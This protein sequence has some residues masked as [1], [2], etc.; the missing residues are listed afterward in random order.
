MGWL[1][2]VLSISGCAETQ[3]RPAEAAPAIAPGRLTR[4]EIET[5]LGHGVRGKTTLRHLYDER[6]RLVATTRAHGAGVAVTTT[7]GYDAAG[8]LASERID[9]GGGLGSETTYDYDAHGWKTRACTVHNVGMLTVVIPDTCTHYEYDAKGRVTRERT[10]MMGRSG[11]IAASSGVE[12]G[13]VEDSAGR[14]VE[15]TRSSGGQAQSRHTYRYDATGHLLEEVFD[16]LQTPGIEEQ[17]FHTYD[18]G[19]Q[20]ERVRRVFGGNRGTGEAE[21]VYR[22]GRVV[23]A[24]GALPAEESFSHSASSTARYFYGAS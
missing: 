13:Y 18:A 15:E 11:T 22:Q 3:A 5:D 8:R 23:S 24:S 10:E 21:Y 14:V 20:L 17:K 7:Y 19:G 4:V 2:L 1:W 16:V 12:I 6:G 9:T